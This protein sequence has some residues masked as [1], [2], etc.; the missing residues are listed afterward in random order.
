MY[1]QINASFHYGSSL[2]FM[3]IEISFLPNL[4]QEIFSIYKKTISTYTLYD[5]DQKVIK[6][7]DNERFCFD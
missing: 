1:K 7:S 6:T 5:S 4:L 2:V 3:Y